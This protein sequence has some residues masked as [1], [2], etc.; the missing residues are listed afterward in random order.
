MK[1]VSTQLLMLLLCAMP[2]ILRGQTNETFTSGAFIIDMGVVPQ[3]L[4][5]GLKPYGMIYDLIKNYSVPIKWVISQTKLKDGI[6]FTYAAKDYKGGPFIIPA[7]YRNATI[8]ARI[9]YWQTQGIIGTTTT[10][11]LT[12]PVTYTIRAVPTWTVNSANSAIAIAYLTNAGIPTTAYNLLLP[13]EL[14]CCNDLFLMPHADPTWAT[15]SNLLTWNKNCKGSIW[16]GCHAVSV[17]EGVFDPAN[18]TTKM[19]F[20][21]DP[22][23]VNFRS[24][25]AG[26]VP[27]TYDY[28]TEA[29][30]QFMGTYDGAQQNGSEQIYMPSLGGGWRPT[31]K[32][33][34]F[35]P[36]QANVPSISPGP[37]A[38]TVFGRAFG[39][40]TRGYVM[41]EGGHNLANGTI[42][43]QVAAQRAMLNFSF[44]QSF[45]KVVVPIVA[46]V[47]DTLY[48]GIGSTVT[49]TLPAPYN[50]ADY[51]MQWSAACGG[52]F[53]PNGTQQTVT[54]TP[55]SVTT[56]TPC[57]IG[58]QI[59]DVCGRKTT[60]NKVAT[61][62]CSLVVSATPTNPSCGTGTGS[63]AL[64]V[65]GGTTPYSFN[66][67]NGALTGSGTGTTISGLVAG[68]YAITV[69]SANGCSSAT[70]ATITTDTPLSIADP[71]VTN[72]LCSGTS[73]GAITIAVSG[74][75]SPYS[76]NWGSGVTTQNRTALAAGTYNVTV[77]DAK[78]CTATATATVT[79][80]TALAASTTQTNIAC[81]GASTGAINLTATGGTSPYTYNWGGGVTT[82]NRTGLAAGTYIVTVTDANNCTKTAVTTLTQP[83]AA[84]AIA[85]NVTNISCGSG[86]GSITLNVSG[87]TSPYTY[88]WG[89]GITTQNRTGL[90]AGTYTVTVTDANSCISTT[91][92]TVTASTGLTLT[93]SVTNVNCFGGSTGA[94]NLTVSS[95]TTPYTYNWGGGVTTQNRTALAAGSYT[96]TVTDASGCSGTTT[97]TLTQPAT[98]LDATAT[99]TNV[100]CGGGTTGTINITPTG[101]TSPYTYDWGGGITTQ[102]RT[103]LAAGTY[104]VTVTDAKGC[105][106][107]VM[108]TITQPLVLA[109]SLTKTDVSCTG[110]TDGAINLTV[111]GGTS[112]YTYN[113]GGGITT[114]N[115]TG[116]SVG[117]YTVTVTDANNCTASASTTLV[118]LKSVPM[119][120]VIQH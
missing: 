19:N 86:T 39:D 85:S 32:V 61:L 12:L 63:V 56:A 79:Q 43:E 87:G 10:T 81:F 106:K 95:G 13:S 70:S 9:A 109:L 48:S 107:T 8:N 46:N 91:S 1:Q 120:P 78:N 40:N 28:P 29:V 97:I 90:A 33:A 35:D 34:V 4:G 65:G 23:L 47:P 104:T 51:T 84:L 22:S 80:P 102:N 82:Q 89:G 74:G 77:T 111:S 20:L 54:Y 67:K 75:T 100:T 41:Y 117:T 53:T 5:N 96:V 118:A 36:T 60:A 115:R 26:S 71:T 57:L 55:P 50:V 105:T 62:T 6:D 73:T 25:A 37:A 16:A 17:L 101:G 30:M 45:D 119:N 42:P 31:T 69:T 114:Q 98:A 49:F 2:F 44:L 99:A 113:W 18:P 11:A 21:S 68:T 59:T 93:P 52:T 110:G 14:T 66:W 24:H 116:L 94:I 27:Y 72:A 83:A 7:E 92:A 103:S 112:P 88:N 76:Y 15:H 108:Q 3:T 64:T 58:V 38:S